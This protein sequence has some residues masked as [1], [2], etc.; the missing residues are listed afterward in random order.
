MNPGHN[1]LFLDTLIYIPVNIILFAY[2]TYIWRNTG[3]TS[4]LKYYIVMHILAILFL[5]SNHLSKIV[6]E[7]QM[8]YLLIVAMVIKSCF[9]LSFFC[10]GYYFYHRRHLSKKAIFLIILYPIITIWLIAYKPGFFTVTWLSPLNY[11]N[12]P[13]YPG[14]YIVGYLFQLTGAILISLN[15]RYSSYAIIAS[16]TLFSLKFL[17]ASKVLDSPVDSCPIFFCMIFT[18]LFF[19]AY[20]Y[21]LLS[22]L[23]LGMLQGFEMFNEVVLLFDTD[24]QVIHQNKAFSKYGKDVIFSIIS[25]CQQIIKE[26]SSLTNKE[27]GDRKISVGYLI[28]SISIQPIRSIFGKEIAYVGVI[29][30]DTQVANAINKLDQKNKELAERNESIKILIRDVK[31]LAVLK[32]RN[33]LAGDIHDILGH[34]L[35]YALQVL[36][37]NEVI[38]NKQPEK[39]VQRLRQA[40]KDIDRG[41]GEIKMTQTSNM[42]N[43]FAS[44]YLFKQKLKKMARRFVEVGVE[45]EIITIANLTGSSERLL[46]TIYRI[47]QEAITNSI[48]H[49]QASQVVISIKKKNNEIA[50]NIIDNGKGCT[51]FT[52]GSGLT[53]ME[54]R[55][56]KLGGK[57]TFGSFADK[58]GF[59]IKVIIPLN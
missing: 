56:S 42:K 35:N 8:Q 54:E 30:D 23:S 20:K 32:E 57:I 29:H 6:P 45:V 27:R 49:G 37:S 58:K 13:V 21:G 36:E 18:I 55:I 40:V 31:R 34:S 28:L 7:E 3:K 51:S 50:L 53:G 24:G 46:K 59:L 43:P 15:T 52:K 11:G 41:M 2:L 5:F 9:A 47:C 38:V 22:T 12:N 19:A 17:Y 48:K 44:F 4:I 33:L 26:S 16:F 39:A 14:V 10:F 25:N 1:I